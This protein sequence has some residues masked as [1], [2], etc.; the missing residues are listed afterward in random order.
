VQCHA[1][2][3][4]TDYSADHRTNRPGDHKANPNTYI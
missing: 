3:D 2:P 4:R 1:V